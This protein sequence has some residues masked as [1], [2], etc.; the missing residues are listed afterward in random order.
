LTVT[1][2]SGTSAL[3]SSAVSVLTNPLRVNFNPPSGGGYVGTFPV[4][5]VIDDGSIAKAY[6]F[7]LIVNSAPSTPANQPPYF[8]P[9]PT[10]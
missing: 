7:N 8:S 2:G 5:L 3:I 10:D 4:E 1:V 6:S 9:S